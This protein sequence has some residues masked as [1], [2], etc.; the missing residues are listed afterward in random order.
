M[1]RLFSLVLRCCKCETTKLQR[2][3]NLQQKTVLTYLVTSKKNNDKN[4]QLYYQNIVFFE[5]TY[6][7][8]L[9]SSNHHTSTQEKISALI[10]NKQSEYCFYE[11]IGFTPN[12]SFILSF[13]LSIFQ[14]FNAQNQRVLKT[15]SIRTFF[16]YLRYKWL[17][18]IYTKAF[19][20][21]II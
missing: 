6:L 14:L 2:K 4:D 9:Q 3:F 13:I 19:V 18:L 8:Q 5:N 10:V 16:D 21:D 15:D 12:I 17:F 7:F 1:D 20:L 11:L